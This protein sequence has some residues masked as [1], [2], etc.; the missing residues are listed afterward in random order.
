MTG[1][2]RQFFR[3]ST[4]IAAVGLLGACSA[5][6]RSHGFAPVDEDLARISVGVD[7][8]GSVRRKI[9]RP[10]ASGIFSDQGWYYVS[11]KIEHYL[12]NDPEVVDRKVVAVLFNEND[13]VAS[14]NTYGIED[15]RIIDLET[16]TTPTYGRQLTII[17]QAFG[18]VGVTAEEVFG[19]N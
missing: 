6:V 19:S 14:V 17:E 15:G 1:F 7:T 8:R 5:E 10:G 18:N 12:Y 2:R 16:K 11:T 4:V 13:V 3:T 9:G